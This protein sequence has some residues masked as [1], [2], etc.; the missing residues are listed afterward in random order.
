[1]WRFILIGLHS[2]SINQRTINS[3]KQ[4]LFIFCNYFSKGRAS[5]RKL[6]GRNEKKPM[7]VGENI[8]SRIYPRLGFQANI[9][10][11][12]SI[13]RRNEF[14][15]RAYCIYCR[16]WT[17]IELLYAHIKYPCLSTCDGLIRS[18]NRILFF[19]ISTWCYNKE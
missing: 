15:N 2:S 4:F 7:H 19:L 13:N 12:H 16:Y 17:V 8:F 6:Y 9:L 18:F 3:H 14:H 10:L 5:N 11:N 1:M